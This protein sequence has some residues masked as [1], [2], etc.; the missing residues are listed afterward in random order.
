MTV[1]VADLPVDGKFDSM[2][3]EIRCF[4]GRRAPHYAAYRTSLRV[5]VHFADKDE[6]AARQRKDLAVLTP[7]RGEIDG[8][9]DGWRAGTS[10]GLFGMTNSEAL[11]AKATRYDR[12]VGDA[13]IVALEGDVTTAQLLLAKIKE[14]ILNDRVASARFEYLL[15]AFASALALMFLAW[16]LSAIYYPTPDAADAQGRMLQIGRVFL[17][18]AAVSALGLWLG[19]QK[20]GLTALGLWL[21]KQ[22]SGA[23]AATPS[24]EKKDSELAVLNLWLGKQ[25]PGLTLAILLFAAIAIPA[26]AILISPSFKLQPAP[27]GNPYAAAIDLWRGA[28]AGA[29]GAFFS[30]SLA[31]RGRTILPDLL[32]VSNLMDAMLRIMIGFIAGAVVMALVLAGIVRLWFAENSTDGRT[33][34]LVLITGFIAG[35][36]ERLVPDLLDKASVRPT[37]RPAPVPVPPVAP[38]GG[39]AGGPGGPGPAAPGAGP[40]NAGGP[41]PGNPPPVEPDPIPAQ[42]DEEAC[43]AD[44]ELTDDEMTPDEVLPPASGGIAAD[45]P[46]EEKPQ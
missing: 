21:G 45:V 27:S 3:Q 22:R 24:S 7:V 43:I 30:I 42:A 20:P 23:T 31:I 39:P 2:G 26:Y 12:R 17:V 18:I 44:V 10:H 8:L 19:M 6:D 11:Q 13:L 35:F 15:A 5:M 1:H 9:V 16:L 41:A 4:Y 14:D 32:R 33:V 37:D 36:S 25:R 38:A 28:A 29:V 46:S 40:N 34:L